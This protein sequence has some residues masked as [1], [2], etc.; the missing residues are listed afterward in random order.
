MRVL[1]VIPARGGS[2]SIPR[3]NII[4]VG[5]R[6]LIAWTI[7]QAINSGVI[8]YI[9]VST[10]DAEI[11]DVAKANGAQCEFIRPKELAG[12][13]I[14]T[15]AV[16][17][18]AIT[19]LKNRGEEFDVVVELQPTYCFRGFEIIKQCVKIYLEKKDLLDSVIT[20]VRVEDTSHPDYVLNMGL[21]GLVEFGKK[22]LDEFARQKLDPK[23][24]CRGIVLA[25]SINS[26]LQSKSFFSGK[27]YPVI[28]DDPI[29]AVDINVP[30]DLEIATALAIQYPS[31]LV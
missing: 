28:I 21:N 10:D 6:P 13:T 7:R 19:E 30:L 22:P 29:R 18:N 17:Y 23:Y 25:S 5:G 3:K 12:D 9:H 8:D 2:K 16:I 1:A 11:A 31:M 26:Y 24:A 14:G 4:S 27:C 20:C 15:R